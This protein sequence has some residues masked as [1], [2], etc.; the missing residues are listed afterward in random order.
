MSM[1]AAGTETA[2]TDGSAVP[3]TDEFLKGV[4]KQNPVF[5]QVLGMCPVLAV[6]N[7][8]TNALAMGSATMAVL[9][10]SNLA[11]SC[12]RQVIPPQVRI[13]TYI[14]IIATLVTIVDH[15]IQAWSVEL[16]R[17]LGAFIS[18]IV[19]NCLILGRAEALAAHSSPLRALWDALGMGTGFLLAL[20]CLG[21]V[22]ELIGSGSLFGVAILGPQYQGW[23]V[24]MLPPG[25]FFVL[26][27]W[28]MLFSWVGKPA[29]VETA[30]SRVRASE[31][32]R[33]A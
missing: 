19:V 26:A 21:A 16:H 15:L 5:V 30:E 6:S 27:G 25:G 23:V 4:W 9:V 10:L 14:L 1:G 2:S 24:M 7:T 22:R 17:A 28:L 3:T 8:A 13:V 29:H 33:K 31:S 32:G 11:V 12:L 20:F 18:L